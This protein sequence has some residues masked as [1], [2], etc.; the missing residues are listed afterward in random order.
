MR[1]DRS[2][3][4]GDLAAMLSRKNQEYDYNHPFALVI[5]AVFI[6]GCLLISKLT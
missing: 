2:L 1:E 6:L 4:R 5:L 3:D